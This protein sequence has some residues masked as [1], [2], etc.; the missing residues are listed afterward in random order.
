MTKTRQKSVLVRV[1]VVL[2]F[3]LLLVLGLLLFFEY[4][5]RGIGLAVEGRPGMAGNLVSNPSFEPPTSTTQ[6]CQGGP[7]PHGWRCCTWGQG[8][9]RLQWDSYTAFSGTHSVRIFGLDD[10]VG[11]VWVTDP[12]FPITAGKQYSF[13]GWIRADYLAHRARACVGLYLFDDSGEALEYHESSPVLHSTLSEPRD[14]WVQVKGSAMVPAEAVKARLDAKL[15]GE[16]Y[17]RFDNVIVSECP[18][19]PFLDLQVHAE[20]D[21][22]SPTGI[23]T[24]V[25]AVT[26]TG[27]APASSVRLTSTL[28]SRTTLVYSDTGQLPDELPPGGGLA[29]TLVVSVQVITDANRPLSATFAVSADDVE[30]AVL[31][32]ETLVDPR[33]NFELSGCEP[34]WAVPGVGLEYVHTVTNTSNR[35]IFFTTCA[36]TIPCNC[37]DAIAYPENTG[38]VPSGETVPVTLTFAPFDDQPSLPRDCFPTLM[39]EA[40]NTARKMSTCDT[41]VIADR[42]GLDMDGGPDPVLAGE[43]LTY[44]LHYTYVGG[45]NAQDLRITVTL[46]GPAGISDCIPPADTRSKTMC[47]WLPIPERTGGTGKITVIASVATEATG[48]VTSTAQI[49]AR[50]A[51]PITTVVTT[52]VALRKLYLPVVVR[53]YP[54]PSMVNGGF[55]DGWTG[56]VHGGELSQSIGCTNAR[57][58]NCSALLGNPNYKCEGDVPTGSAWVEQAV[59]VPNTTSPDL[60]FWY[61]IFTQ[62]HDSSLS[63][64]YDS[65][66][67]RINGILVF[68]DANTSDSYGCNVPTKDLGWKIREV[69]LTA[70][71]GQ[72]ITIRFENW[73]RADGWYNTWTYVDDVRILR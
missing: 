69:D 38:P 41:F 55:E 67:V 61:N 39:V 50:D 57:L 53:N 14:G 4:Q 47:L 48:S 72:S 42:L 25:V 71:R 17:V 70:Y 7:A 27:G 51:G 11:A 22:V 29:M 26:N 66:D 13:S 2:G 58:E 46:D 45:V 31:T 28:D 65:F 44:T 16:G 60:Y 52:G 54:I 6:T 62:D 56:W 19:V 63:G 9:A 15:K 10:D 30:P 68:R 33:I 49:A 37:G 64:Q 40:P 1:V 23:L 32:V 34:G 18:I 24:Y 5:G 12:R 73:S 35:P 36:I 59:L 8:N 43:E 21:P 20:P 3:E